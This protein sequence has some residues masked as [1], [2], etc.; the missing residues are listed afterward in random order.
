[1][2]L[3]WIRESWRLIASI[4]VFSLLTLKE[5]AVFKRS[6]SDTNRHFYEAWNMCLPEITPQTIT[7]INHPV[8][9][10]LDRKKV[11]IG[12]DELVPI[13]EMLHL[14]EATN[15]LEIGTSSGGTTWHIAANIGPTGSVV[16]V[17]LPPETR[18]EKY[19]T[20]SLA[21]ERPTREQ[22]GRH[23]RGSTVEN[24]I[25]QILMDSEQLKK[26]SPKEKFDLVFIDASHTYENAK[27]DTEN[28]M[29]L[30]KK[31]GY[32]IW[33][34]YFVFHPDYG[35]RKLLHELASEM[36]VYRLCDSLCGIARHDG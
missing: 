28:A 12:I 23:F 9:I 26:Y 1:M 25:E 20:T 15:V 35:V 17:D 27:R 24:K 6:L 14:S 3:S 11:S 21:T 22:L 32:L 36:K 7:G 16:T 4:S 5:R 8:S 34:D 33:H 31:G 19:T 18:G 10:E 13:L 30:V 2:T 29:R